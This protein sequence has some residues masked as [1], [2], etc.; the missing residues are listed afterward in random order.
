MHLNGKGFVSILSL[1][2][3][4]LLNVR[5]FFDPLNRSYLSNQDLQE[6]AND[7]TGVWGTEAKMG[8]KAERHM[9]VG[10]AI[11]LKGLGLFE[12]GFVVVGGIPAE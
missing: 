8:A 1:V 12:N 3:G 10:L 6:G 5:R 7:Q 2:G 4:F 9:G 11:E